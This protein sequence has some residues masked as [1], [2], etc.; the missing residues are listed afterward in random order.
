MII[1]LNNRQLM[2]LVHLGGLI[3]YTLSK[4]SDFTLFVIGILGLSTC[5]RQ[6]FH[7]E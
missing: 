7:Q 2:L 5:T 1:I 4:T 6:G 3:F